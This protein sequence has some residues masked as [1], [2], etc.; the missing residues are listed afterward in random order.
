MG[1]L[2]HSYVKKPKV[3]LQKI[4]EAWSEHTDEGGE[5]QNRGW[6]G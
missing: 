6:I 2:Y 5:G 3:A 4:L 1:Y